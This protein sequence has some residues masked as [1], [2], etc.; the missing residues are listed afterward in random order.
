MVREKVVREKVTRIDED[1][2]RIREKTTIEEFDD[3]F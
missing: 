3:D 2:D 1:A